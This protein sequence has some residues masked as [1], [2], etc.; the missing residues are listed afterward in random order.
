MKVLFH[1]K[2]YLASFS[3][4]SLSGIHTNLCTLLQ[5]YFWQMNNV[6]TKDSKGH[7]DWEGAEIT[8]ARAFVRVL[9]HTGLLG[10]HDRDTFLFRQMLSTARPVGD[11]RSESVFKMH[12]PQSWM[13]VSFK[14]WYFIAQRSYQRCAGTSR[15]A[16][17]QLES[18]HLSQRGLVKSIITGENNS[19]QTPNMLLCV[20]CL[21]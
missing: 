21:S 20:D 18:C 19:V 3:P 17:S 6:L 11:L 14:L 5:N 10:I 1:K 8:A 15:R 13:A 12:L 2:T 7:A 4:P 16:V 9:Q